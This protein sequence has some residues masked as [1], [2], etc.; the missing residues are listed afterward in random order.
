MSDNANL[1]A[2]LAAGFDHGADFLELQDGTRYTYGDA[3]RASAQVAHALGALGLKTGDCA[4]VVAEKSVALVWLYLGCLR[5][6]VIYQPLNSSYSERELAFFIGNSG[7]RLVVHDPQ[8]EGRIEAACAQCASAPRRMTL[9]AHGEGEIAAA[10]AAADTQ[11][12]THHASGDGVAALLYSSGTTGTPKGIPITHDNLFRNAVALR[13]TWGFVREDV[14]LHA[15][16]FYHVHGLFITLHPAMLA[17]MRLRFHARFE[18]EE[19]LQ[20]LAGA[21]LF[22][23]VPTYYTRLL[24]LAGF[25]RDACASVR[26]FISGSA[27]LLEST[28]HEFSARTGQVILER[29]GM[30]E[31]GI[32]TSNPLHG[33]R[34]AGSV[35][36]PL[37]GTD[38]RIV[39]EQGAPLAQGEIGEIEVRG[40][41]V[42]RGYW[43]LPE[44]SASAFSADGFFRTGDQGRFDED[45]YLFIVG[46]S[47]DMIISGGLNVYPKEIESELDELPNVVESAVFGVP[48]PDF[49]EAVMAAVIPRGEF[50]E[51][52]VL[53][54]LRARLAGFKLPKRIVIVSDL[55]R[56]TM[57][58][59][60]KSRLRDSYAD[61][62]IANARG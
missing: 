2:R 12:E 5:A 10:W 38:V 60:Q 26:L 1:Y 4:A 62:F 49:G 14:L 33:E 13:D 41:N 35:G 23:G 32:N 58:K 3:E 50:D 6:G 55:P 19:V 9:D 27:P 30:T 34:R 22:A 44:Q 59:V 18:A 28:F 46:R 51:A 20:G 40:P 48:H 29:Y 56:N 36:L 25:N 7:A 15:L 42:F 52:A 31:T 45:G 57:G 37:A 43:R 54:H 53:A 17:G 61:A 8:L 39:S 16:P 24:S 47:K 11:F 21:S